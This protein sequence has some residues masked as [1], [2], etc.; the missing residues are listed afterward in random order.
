MKVLVSG[1]GGFV[2]RF[3]VQRLLERGHNVRAI[4]RKSIAAPLWDGDVEIFQADLRASD[5]SEAFDGVD[6]VIHLAAAVT[7]NEDV[8]FASTAVGT[9]RFIEAMARSATRCLVHVSSIAVYDWSRVRRTMD[10]E[11]PLVKNPYEM[12]GY[13][14][15]KIWQER[16]VVRAAEEHKWDLTIMRPGFI[17][18]PGH[19]S[20]A[21]MGRQFGRLFLTFGLFNRLP[22]SEVRNCA[23]C[24]V[25]A[26]ETQLPGKHVFNVFDSDGVRVLRYVSEFK[27]R[28]SQRG[29]I[30]P[31]PYRLGLGIAMLA[32]LTS[33][34]LFGKKGKLPSL[35]IP[36]RYES[37][38]KSA[39]FSNEKIKKELGWVQ[40]YNFLESLEFAFGKDERNI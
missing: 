18:G 12:G 23:D 24:L 5:L 1:A 2:G 32:K 20:I 38:F 27:R 31:I 17:W 25:L 29:A 26:V 36:R 10:E 6:A 35:L 30:I 16:L 33:R 28:S 11:T 40:R 21:G 4:V 22:L 19:A 15:A 7:G 34:L 14:I 13:T 39:H 3:V 8:Q 37:Q 9:E